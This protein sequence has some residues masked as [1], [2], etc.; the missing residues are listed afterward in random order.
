M[1]PENWCGYAST[2]WSRL[3]DADPVEHLDGVRPGHLLR[4]LVV[5]PVGLD[6]LVADRVE[7]VHRGQRV[8]E[9]HRHLLAA[10]L[11]YVVL[12]GT[13]ELFTVEPDLAGDLA[14]FDAV[15]RPMID[16]LVT[17]LPDP[18]SPTMPRVLPRSQLEGEPVHRLDQH[19]PRS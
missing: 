15:C 1:P 14:A 6:D 19:R 13:D 2:R 9:D 16:M 5:H 7:G 12:V 17:D 11:A 3:R 10:Q 4:H 8:L 18:D